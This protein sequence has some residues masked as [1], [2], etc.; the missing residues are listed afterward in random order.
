VRIG[1]EEPHIYSHRGQDDVALNR[2]F[3]G[4]SKGHYRPFQ[5]NH[6]DVPGTRRTW[7]SF[8]VETIAEPGRRLIKPIQLLNEVTAKKVNKQ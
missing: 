1:S 5:K 2:G 6:N 4:I 7:Q 3:S 8:V